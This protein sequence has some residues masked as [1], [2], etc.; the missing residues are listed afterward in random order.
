MIFPRGTDEV[1]HRPAAESCDRPGD[2]EGAHATKSPVPRRTRA[3]RDGMRTSIG[4]A[5][6]PRNNSFGFLR[7][8]FALLVVVD[9]AFPLGGYNGGVDPMWAWT[10]GQEDIG[11]MAVAG[12][13][14][15]SGFLVTRSFEG[16]PNV[17]RYLWKRILR[18]F[19]GFWVCLAVTA[20]VFGTIATLYQHGTLSGYFNL[21]S[22]G[23]VGYIYHNAFLNMNQ[24][25]I[26]GLLY[27]TPYSHTGYPQAFDGSLWTLIYEFKC[28]IGVAI[29]G[30]LTLTKRSRRIGPI[31]LSLLFWVAQIEDYANP[32]LLAG[33]PLIGDI[34]MARLGF[35]FSL[36][37]L[38]YLYRQ[39]IPCSWTLAGVAMVVYLVGMR[40]GL[41]EGIGQAAFAYLCLF[42][43]IKLP[44]K[45]F[46]KYGDFSYGIYIYSFPIEQLCALF[47]AEHF[48]YPAYV[49]ISIA[50]T[51]VFAVPSWFLVE[52]PCLRLKGVRFAGI[53]KTTWL[54]VSRDQRK[55]AVS[56]PDLAAPREAMG[57]DVP[58]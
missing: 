45:R 24:W 39:S 17:V 37:M 10:K 44:L 28:Y 4:Q 8:V 55:I 14:V 50:G 42:A 9:H 58:H 54:P 30:I 53:A 35:I 26:N 1:A 7:T 29:L 22:V 57:T 2:A 47:G 12:F 13:F 27:G 32:H 48:G 18:I 33:I 41:Y 23:P 56:E 11:G 34:N 52:R 49:A 51:M 5:F 15:L 43:A 40:T 6:D 36:G 20:L 16:S 31:V 46:D 25:D 38:L 3:T 21:S 19:P